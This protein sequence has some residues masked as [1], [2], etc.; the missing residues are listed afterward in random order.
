MRQSRIKS[1]IEQFMNI[2][3]GFIVSLLIWSYVIVPVWGIETNFHDN[4][5]ITLIFTVVSIIRGYI[6]RRIFNKIG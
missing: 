4:L 6:W 2:G 1:L 5:H 3:S